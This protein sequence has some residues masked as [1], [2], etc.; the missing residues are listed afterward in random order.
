[1]ERGYGISEVLDRISGRQAY[2][3]PGEGEVLAGEII[4]K[5]E[6]KSLRRDSNSRIHFY[7]SFVL[8]DHLARWMRK[9]EYTYR[10]VVFNDDIENMQ[11][12]EGRFYIIINSVKVR[13]M[14][15]MNLR[16]G[17]TNFEFLLD[18]HSF[19]KPYF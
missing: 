18:E 1:M 6:I 9:K 16:E 4:F 2:E 14:L 3:L 15:G 8:V 10:L 19:I 11:L 7:Q 5:S 17:Q 13:N 12:R